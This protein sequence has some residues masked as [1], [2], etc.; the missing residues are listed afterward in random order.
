MADVTAGSE[1]FA[2]GCWSLRAGTARAEAPLLG[3]LFVDHAVLQRD[4]DIN[5]YG[6][7]TPRA[8]GHCHA[9]GCNGT[10][11]SG[12]TGRVVAD[13]AGDGRG[14]SAYPRR[15]RGRE[16]RRPSTDVLVGDVWLCS[17]QSNMEWPVRMTLDAGSE[18]ALS[19]NDAHPPR[20]HRARAQRRAAR[21]ISM[22]RSNGRSPA[23][24]RPN[25]S[26]PRVTTSCASCR[27][28]WTRRR[29]SSPRTGAASR[30]EPWMS[31]EAL[32]RQVDGYQKPARVVRRI[33]HRQTAG[34][35]AL[36]RDL[37]EVVD[38]AAG[39]AAA[40]SRGS[41]S[42]QDNVDA[43]ACG[44]RLLGNLERAGAR[45]ATTAWCG[46]ARA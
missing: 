21:A 22:R 6:Q 29:A 3:P 43:G 18:V 38:R 34:V 8:G 4:R 17:G 14:R 36:G 30:I 20:H 2:G 19:A 33:P 7:A 45:R 26:P 46:S 44:A 12:R 1:E 31:E 24:R 35:R 9:R 25:I 42:T 28:P 39:H 37:A 41:R 5:V 23:R 32:A 11:E 16:D 13:T 40:A 10:R 27:K 15:A